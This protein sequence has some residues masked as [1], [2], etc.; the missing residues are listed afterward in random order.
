MKEGE[1][2]RNEGKEKE[3]ILIG[4]LE[5]RD[6]ARRKKKKKSLPMIHSHTWKRATALLPLVAFTEHLLCVGPYSI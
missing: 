2:E 5:D 3:R 4:P 1:K 6:I